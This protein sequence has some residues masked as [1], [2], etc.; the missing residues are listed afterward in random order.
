[1]KDF[2]NSYDIHSLIKQATCYKNT[3]NPTC[4]DMI[5]TNVLLSFQSAW[6]LDTGKSIFD[7]MMLSIMKKIF[8]KLHRRNITYRSCNYF[9]NETFR[10]KLLRKLSKINLVNKGKAFEKFSDI[11][12]DTF[13][14][15]TPWNKKKLEEIKCLFLLKIL[16]NPIKPGENHFYPRL[17]KLLL[18]EKRQTLKKKLCNFQYIFI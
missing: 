16:L 12:M 15:Y 8:K 9:F 7:L 18:A 10:K 5:L 4:I 1:M 2:C 17:E 14:R 11:T 3:E 13:T 6:A